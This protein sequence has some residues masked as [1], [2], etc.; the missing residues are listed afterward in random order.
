MHIITL[1]PAQI[2]DHLTDDG[3]ELTQLP[4]PFHVTDDGLVLHQDFWQ[5]SPAR[6]IGFAARVDVHSIDL[7]W[8]EA[9]AEPQRAVGMYVVSADEKNTWATHTVVIESVTESWRPA[10]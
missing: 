4:Y 5:G 8:S 1:Q 7:D 3:H 2:T 10:S 6:I 9:V